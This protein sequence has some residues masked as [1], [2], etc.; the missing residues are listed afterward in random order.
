MAEING[1][2]G[3]VCTSKSSGI[4]LLVCYSDSSD[5]EN[6]NLNHDPALDLVEPTIRLF[7][8]ADNKAITEVKET[9]IDLTN[10]RRS[11]SSF[12]SDETSSLSSSED[13]SDEDSS[14]TSSSESSENK[15]PTNNS[16]TR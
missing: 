5:S 13:S 12:E 1:S 6:E 3:E 4:K 10:D 8:D 9:I 16:S 7:P 14:D 11:V 15:R 2:S